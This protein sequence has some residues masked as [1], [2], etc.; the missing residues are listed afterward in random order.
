MKLLDDVKLLNDNYK[1]KGLTKGMIGT[2]VDADIRW[3]CFCVNFQD[4]RIYDK[5]FINNEESLLK[6]K[7]DI[8]TEIKIED[9][10]VI[11]SSDCTDEYL[12]EN[13]PL[14]YKDCWCKVENGYIMNAEGKKKNK[15]PYDYNS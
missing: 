13:L 11:K 7:N 4:Q 8:Y 10:E 3:N 14:A 1:N 9:M 6:L 12:K 2:I 15:I 5:N